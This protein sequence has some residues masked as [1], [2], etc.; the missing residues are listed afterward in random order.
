MGPF[1]PAGPQSRSVTGGEGPVRWGQPGGS[2]PSPDLSSLFCWGEQPL[3]PPEGVLVLGPP[4]RPQEGL[5]VQPGGR[6]PRGSSRTGLGDD[7]F[8]LAG[9]SVSQGRS[10]RATCPPS[11]VA[12]AWSPPHA[13]SPPNSCAARPALPAVGALLFSGVTLEHKQLCSSSPVNYIMS[14]EQD[15]AE[16]IKP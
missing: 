10:P 13:P 2:L 11:R 6:M 9:G 15:Q 5:V 14:N 3:H 7:A 8:G 1:I 4:A 12:P 16:G